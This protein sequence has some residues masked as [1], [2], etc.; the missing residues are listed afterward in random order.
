MPPNPEFITPPAIP[1]DKTPSL[2]EKE[3][4][5]EYNEKIGES[6]N[7]EIPQ[8][9]PL[10]DNGKSDDGKIDDNNSDDNNSNELKNMPNRN[11]GHTDK[12]RVPGSTRRER[13]KRSRESVPFPNAGFGGK[14]KRS[15]R[16]AKKTKK[17]KRKGRKSKKSRK[18]KKH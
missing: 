2:K 11:V 9:V 4:L 14:T 6:D 10:D 17:A 12:K 13:K 15:K 3:T 7:H 1:T 16:K 5:T 18:A 8:D